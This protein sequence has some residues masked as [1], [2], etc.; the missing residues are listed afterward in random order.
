MNEKLRKIG[1]RTYCLENV[2][3]IGF[4]L[5]NNCDICLID[6]GSSKDYAKIIDK[7]LIENNWNLKYII[8]T[9][10][11]ADHIGG[12]NY[13]QNKYNCEVF[14]SRLES[15]FINIP[16]L[17]PAFMYGASPIKDVM[18]HVFYAKESVCKDINGVEIEGLQ[19]ISLAGHSIDQ[20]GIVTS[21]K[22]CFAGDAYSS[23]NIVEKYSIQYIYDVGKYIKSLQSLLDS[24]YDYYIPA[25]GMIEKK[26]SAFNTLEKNLETCLNVKDIILSIV[27]KKITIS[28]LVKKVFE[29]YNIKI[30]SVQYHVVLATIKAYLKYLEENEKVVFGYEDNEMFVYKNVI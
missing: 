13:L 16:V 7:I 29:K 23:T 19:V 9:H 25:H 20:I 8:N 12:N 27:G 4:Y 6:S 11:H 17:E 26:S 24:N 3:N 1:K 22:V 14:S 18:N 2:V 5:L 30:N 10:S 21:D 15:Y 28:D